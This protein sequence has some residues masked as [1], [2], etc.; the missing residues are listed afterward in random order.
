[1]TGAAA[2]RFQAVGNIAFAGMAGSPRKMDCFRA[3]AVSG[4][5]CQRLFGAVEAP[6]ETSGFVAGFGHGG[7]N[8]GGFRWGAAGCL[9][10]FP[11]CGQYCVARPA[12]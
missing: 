9:G 10:L 5:F 4:G 11:G 8:C 6:S 12:Q 2:G 3:V 7:D 1:M